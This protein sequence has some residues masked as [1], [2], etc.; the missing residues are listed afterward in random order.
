MSWKL[1]LKDNFCFQKCNG[2]NCTIKDII[3]SDRYNCQINKYLVYEGNILYIYSNCDNSE[4]CTLEGCLNC[5]TPDECGI[6]SQGYYNIEGICKTY[7][8]GSSICS[9]NYTCDYCFSGYRLNND[10]K[11]ELNNILDFNIDLYIYHKENLYKMFHKNENYIK[12]EKNNSYIKICDRNCKSC[13]DN[14]GMQRMHKTIYFRE[15]HM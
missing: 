3:Y 10:G 14:T 5:S 6:C 2:L 7:I 11:C 4:Q 13:Y 8:E 1:F 15:Q 12:S 9:N